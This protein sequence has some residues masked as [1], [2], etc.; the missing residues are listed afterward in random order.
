MDDDHGQPA[1]SIQNERERLIGLDPTLKEEE[2][3]PTSQWVSG[4]DLFPPRLTEDQAES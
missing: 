1:G 2:I 4:A 3:E